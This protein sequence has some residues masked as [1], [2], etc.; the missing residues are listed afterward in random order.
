MM[1]ARRSCPRGRGRDIGPMG[2]LDHKAGSVGGLWTAAHPPLLIWQM[3]GLAALFGPSEWA[4]RAPAAVAG[5]GCVLVLYLLVRRLAI[6][7]AVAR[8]AAGALLL[9]P[10]FT[11]DRKSTRLNSSHMSIS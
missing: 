1:K 9:T 4:L 8:I 11:Q 3:A 6:D 2:W 5:I 7:P 10:Y